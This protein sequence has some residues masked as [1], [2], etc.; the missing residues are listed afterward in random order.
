MTHAAET[1][2]DKENEIF[3]K[4]K[5]KATVKERVDIA[6]SDKHSKTIPIR[7]NK[8]KLGDCLV[9]LLQHRQ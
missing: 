8:W 2:K 5:G 3:K 7:V 6:V 9:E 4:K 1:L